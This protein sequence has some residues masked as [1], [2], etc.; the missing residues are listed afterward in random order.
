MADQAGANATGAAASRPGGI[1][2]KV[3][4]G[5]LVLAGALLGSVAVGF[6]AGLA[7]PR[8]PGLE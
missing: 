1:Q 3:L 7:R 5:L 4:I 6:I 8:E 2:R